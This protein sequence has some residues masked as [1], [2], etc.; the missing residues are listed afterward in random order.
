VKKIAN[1]R[2]YVVALLFAATAISYI[3][4][5]NLAVLAP[6]LR[7]ELG[8]SNSGYAQI[9]S[10]FLLAYTIMQAVTG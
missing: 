6:M 1:V 8:I 9:I 3:D 7:D 5:Q 2:W 10:A 4:R